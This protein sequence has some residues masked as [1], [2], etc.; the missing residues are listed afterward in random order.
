ME[1]HQVSIRF[2]CEYL[3]V[4]VS[5]FYYQPKLSSENAVI[6]DWLLRL[7]TANRR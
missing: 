1:R 4:S 5:C 6:A 7:T 3:G 2:A